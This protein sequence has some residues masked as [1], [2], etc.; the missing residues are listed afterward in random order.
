MQAGAREI[1][2]PPRLL[3]WVGYGTLFIPNLVVAQ[4]KIWHEKLDLHVLQFSAKFHRDRCDAIRHDNI[5]KRNIFKYITFYIYLLY[6]T[7]PEK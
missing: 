6:R 2:I 1:S 7:E 4:T 5:V 3:N